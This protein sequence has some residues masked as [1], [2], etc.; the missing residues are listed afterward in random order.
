MRSLGTS[1]YLLSISVGMYLAGAL[2]MAVAAAS[3]HDPWLANNTL[4][5]RY[6]MCVVGGWAVGASAGVVGAARVLQ[7]C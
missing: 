4:Y 2:N 6:D 3:P 7:R 5:G 1:V